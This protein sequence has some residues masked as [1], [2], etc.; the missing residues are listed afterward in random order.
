[1]ELEYPD[2]LLYAESHEYVRLE[3][4]IAIIG[5]S[6]FLLDQLGEVEQIKLPEEGDEVEQGES[7]GTIKSVRGV[8]NIHA[9]VSGLLIERNQSLLNA[10]EAITDDPY[11]DGWLMKIELVDVEDENEDAL[12]DM[13]SAQAYRIQLEELE[14]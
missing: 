5:L 14:D 4:N 12:A 1:M 8:E 9:P 11:G 2:D 13:L 6:T 10:P 3:E 7:V